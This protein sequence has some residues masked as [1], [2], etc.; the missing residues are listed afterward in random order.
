M[1]MP[2][3]AWSS[4][5]PHA[6]F[7]STVCLSHRLDALLLNFSKK[8]YSLIFPSRTAK[9]MSL[10]FFN[11][12][13]ANHTYRCALAQNN[14]ITTYFFCGNSILCYRRRTLDANNTKD[15][16]A[17]C[18]R[19]RPTRSQHRLPRNPMVFSTRSLQSIRAC[20]QNR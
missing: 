19:F 5:L 17:H 13:Q 16:A 15:Y 3:C 2:L 14:R 1:Y 12:K 18:F 6:L 7:Y 10:L 9:A 8:D 11:E 20:C 4:G